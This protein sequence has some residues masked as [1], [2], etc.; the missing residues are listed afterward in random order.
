MKTV[1]N[2]GFACTC[3]TWLMVNAITKKPVS[4]LCYICFLPL[5]C[6]GVF[7]FYTVR[8]YQHI[9][10][11]VYYIYLFSFCTIFYQQ[12]ILSCISLYFPVFWNILSCISLYFLYFGTF[13]PVLSSFSPR[14]CPVF[15]YYFKNLLWEACCC[16]RFYRFFVSV[17]QN[18]IFSSYVITFDR[19]CENK[20]RQNCCLFKNFM[21]RRHRPFWASIMIGGDYSNVVCV[22]R[23]LASSARILRVFKTTS[24]H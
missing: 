14:F 6:I 10:L 23:R 2:L 5:A 3:Y 20:R 24:A 19:L 22:F 16:F 1:E 21:N 17:F 4:K 12:K 8:N 7:S 11:L 18:F 13:C 15:L 9:Y